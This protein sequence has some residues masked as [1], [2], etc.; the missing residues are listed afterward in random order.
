TMA[1]VMGMDLVADSRMSRTGMASSEA[2]AIGKAQ[3]GLIWLRIGRIVKQRW[4]NR[5]GRMRDDAEAGKS[6]DD[7]GVEAWLA[8]VRSRP[9]TA[10][11]SMS[12]D[13][14]DLSVHKAPR[15]CAEPTRAVTAADGPACALALWEISLT[16][17]TA[18]VTRRARPREEITTHACT[19]GP[20]YLGPNY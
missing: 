2:R 18:L 19:S 6:M 17:P 1:S 16:T 4:E 13:P 3:L 11:P 5:L 7:E 20:S 15:L 8:R 9:V 10:D 14:A 12:R